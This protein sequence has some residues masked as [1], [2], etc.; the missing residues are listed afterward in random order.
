MMRV[1]R[2]TRI[3][4]A[5][6]TDEH[7]SHPDDFDLAAFWQEWCA[8]FESSRAY[9]PVVARI[10]PTLIPY[11]SHIFG[12]TIRDKVAQTTPDNQGFIT[13]ELPFETFENARERILG[14]GRAVEVLE[15]EPLRRS[16]QDFAEQI[17]DL[18]AT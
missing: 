18:Y 14:L 1:Y 4:D 9:Y 7:F 12:L 2:L 17:V 8:E 16:I 13:L 10:A 5:Q 11:L 6:L 15:P 3:L